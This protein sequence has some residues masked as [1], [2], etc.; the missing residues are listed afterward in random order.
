MSEVK[1]IPEDIGEYL[2]YDPDTGALVWLADRTGGIKAGDPAGCSYNMR[3]YRRV[4]FRGSGYLSHRVS[5]FLYHGEQPPK[6]IDH[7]NGD[8][9]DNRIENL[10]G[11]TTTQNQ[12]NSRLRSDNS[13]GFKGVTFDKR[14]GSFRAKASKKYL[15]SYNTPEE[16]D[17]VARAFREKH[18]GEFTNHG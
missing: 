16:A 9:S 1:L 17:S 11:V 10:R 13:T 4:K 14:C 6:N 5:W 12:W 3:G 18:N 2:S 7:I 8:T 15:G